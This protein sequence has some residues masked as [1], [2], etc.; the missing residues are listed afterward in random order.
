MLP[1]IR[2]YFRIGLDP[3]SMLCALLRNDEQGAIKLS[4]AVIRQNAFLKDPSWPNLDFVKLIKVLPTDCK[5]PNVD[6]WISTGGYIG[7]TDEVK[8]FIKLQINPR[9]LAYLMESSKNL[10]NED[11]T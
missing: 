7:Q 2:H 6:T 5:G 4:H 3:G 10:H 1:A 9:V 11:L 8:A